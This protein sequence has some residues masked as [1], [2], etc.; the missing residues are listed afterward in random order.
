MLDRLLEVSVD[1]IAVLDASTRPLELSRSW[2]VLG[3]SRD[4]LFATPFVDLLHPEDR[5][6]IAPEIPSVAAGLAVSG[7]EAR[8]RTKAGGYRWMKGGVVGDPATGT[9]VL[10]VVDIEERKAL[11][12]ALE[13]QLRLEE[14]VAT[15]ATR[16]IGIDP[17]GAI[18]AI[19]RSLETLGRTLGMDRA[20]FLRGVR[21]PDDVTYLEWYNP[22]TPQPAHVPHPDR[23][24]Q[25]W[26]LRTLRD[27]RDLVLDDV[28]EL[29]AEAAQVVD[30]LQEDGVRSLVHISLPSHRRRWGF[31][32]LSSIGRAVAVPAAQVA[33]LRLAGES[34]LMALTS[35]EDQLALTEAQQELHNRNEALERSN[36][37][38]ERF[39]FAAAHDLKAP[40]ARMEMALAAAPASGP[41]TEPLD[42]AR[43]GATRMR[44][45]IEDLLAFAAVGQRAGEACS[46]ELDEVL[47]E[48][49]AD[50]DPLV[51]ASGITVDRAPLPTVVGHRALLGQLL[52]N[53]V[54]NALKFARDDRPPVVRVTASERD[55]GDLLVV[56][57]NGIGVP[58]DRREDVFTVFTRL[59]PSDAYPGSGVG[60]ATCA[61]VVEHHGGR[62]WLEDG[63]DGGT[64]VHVWLPR[65]VDE[66]GGAADA[67][68]AG[69]LG[70][71]V[72][73]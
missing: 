55:G 43:R 39:A 70:R 9:I 6:A 8:M 66:S 32:T 46:V 26:W 25:R 56:A 3:W 69:G 45:L 4:E 7:I 38:L 35:C 52:Q 48:V 1:L 31:L 58:A 54:G 29:R 28:E 44:Q 22:D 62:I 65:L 23:E 24:V 16:L 12:A 18:S 2:G 33:L 10:T 73:R 50:L 57:D 71:G 11:D 14:T 49:L 40:L 15:I 21:Y 30:A 59:N 20:H 51:E 5:A 17:A 34:F 37:E 42:V 64:A 27:G 47:D 63:I 72:V 68:P 60:L 67:S 19:E 36:E 53:L 61:R 13:A 41:V